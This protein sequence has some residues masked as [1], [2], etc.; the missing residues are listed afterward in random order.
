MT[1]FIS[2]QVS[3]YVNNAASQDENILAGPIRAA[4][5]GL[6]QARH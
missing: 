5:G 6:R 1:I 2:A 3:G 4:R